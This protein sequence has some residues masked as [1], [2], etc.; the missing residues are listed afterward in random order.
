MRF[1]DT[2]TSRFLTFTKFTSTHI[3]LLTKI[4]PSLTPQHWFNILL[5]KFGVFYSSKGTV[6]ACVTKRP[7]RGNSSLFWATSL[8]AYKHKFFHLD[9]M[10]NQKTKHSSEI[11]LTSFNGYWVILMFSLVILYI[12]FWLNRWY[13]ENYILW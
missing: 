12:C 9:S 7:Y 4:Q 1:W 6:N 5:E 8:F 13:S 11:E 3:R 10:V 2:E